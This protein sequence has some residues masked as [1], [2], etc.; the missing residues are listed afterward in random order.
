MLRVR[1]GS[2]SW[3]PPSERAVAILYATPEGYVT[4]RA[5]LP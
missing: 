3:I 2:A 1:T 5:A 4:D